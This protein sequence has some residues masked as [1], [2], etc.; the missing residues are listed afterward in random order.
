M[1]TSANIIRVGT[2]RRMSGAGHVTCV[3]INE[4]SLW[5]KTEGNR[6]FGRHT[7]RLMIILER[8]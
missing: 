7:R 8:M 1:Q 2:S 6:L 4:H 3:G 5:W